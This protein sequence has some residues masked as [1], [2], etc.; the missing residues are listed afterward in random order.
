MSVVSL[1]GKPASYVWVM[2]AGDF[3]NE[4]YLI[5]MGPTGKRLL[6]IQFGQSGEIDIDPRTNIVWASEIGDVDNIHYEQVVKVDH[7]GN[8][9]DRFQGY[10]STFM[11]VD[12]R[13]GSVWLNSWNPRVR[14]CLRQVGSALPLRDDQ[15]QQRKCL[16]RRL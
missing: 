5:K 3:K 9:I 11:A 2:D 1:I 10:P 14:S 12:P 13:D 16:G 4:T 8:I 6:Q 7:E 15:P